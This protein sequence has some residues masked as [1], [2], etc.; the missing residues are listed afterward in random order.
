MRRTLLLLAVMAAV[1]VMASEVALAVARSGGP[2]D[3]TLRGTN[4]PDA[5]S[6]KGGNDDLFGLRGTD[7]LSGGAGRDLVLGGNEAGPLLGDRA[8]SGGPGGDF[9]GGGNGSDALS[10]GPG[11]DGIFAGPPFGE[12]A[13]DVDAISAGGGNDAIEAKNVPAARD[14]ID[15]GGGFDRVLIDSKDVTSDCEREFT[16]PGAYFESISSPSYDYFAPFYL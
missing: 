2:G 16:R 7:A 3:D 12:T 14:V 4:G 5:L 9:V 11:R 15:C 10:G 8:L 6:G 1:L 13:D